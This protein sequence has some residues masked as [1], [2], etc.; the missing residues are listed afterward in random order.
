MISSLNRLGRVRPFL[1]PSPPPL[2]LRS[3]TFSCS[4]PSLRQSADSIDGRRQTFIDF[5]KQMAK[6]AQALGDIDPE[7]DDMPVSPLKRL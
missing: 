3:S 7:N 1:S 5:R 4:E 2:L 6:V